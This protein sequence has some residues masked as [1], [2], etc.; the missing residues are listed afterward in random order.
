MTCE[1]FTETLD[2]LLDGELGEPERS[3]VCAHL[4]Q[5][6]SCREVADTQRQFREE[7][8][9][10]ADTGPLPDA[11]RD[12]IDAALAAAPPPGRAGPEP[13]RLAAAAAGILGLLG[14]VFVA[15]T[16]LP[17]A[18]Q[19]TVAAADSSELLQFVDGPNSVVDQSV[20][21]HRREVPV[22]VT[23]PDEFAVRDWFADKVDFPVLPPDFRRRAH[24]L[25]GRLGNIDDDEAAFL[26]Y[27]VGGTKLSVMVFDAQGRLAPVV[28]DREGRPVSTLVRS[29]GSYNVA[30]QEVGGVAYTFTATLPDTELVDLVNAAFSY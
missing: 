12:R 20:R 23:G 28:H 1:D 15:S 24:L 2:L 9:A 6:T 18:E 13:G 26:V 21:W 27:D 17:D 7:L 14:F 25:G 4:E 3:E 16:A 8:R 22:E 5:C 19:S 10:L 11:F 29:S 30:V